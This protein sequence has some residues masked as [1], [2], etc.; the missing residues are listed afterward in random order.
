[1]FDI[2]DLRGG[3]ITVCAELDQD[4]QQTQYNLTVEEG[5]IL[6][7]VTSACGCLYVTLSLITSIFFI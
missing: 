1:M 4:A 3:N 2:F 5:C 7:I 6:N